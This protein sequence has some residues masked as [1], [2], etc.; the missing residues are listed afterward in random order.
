VNSSLAEHS[1]VTA[2][3]GDVGETASKDKQESLTV[4]MPDEVE[5]SKSKEKCQLESS[6]VPEK[7]LLEEEGPVT[8]E[9][10]SG[11]DVQEK[12]QSQDVEEVS[13]EVEEEHVLK[14]KPE[15][16]YTMVSVT[17]SHART[18]LAHMCP[19]WN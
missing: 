14:N 17:A 6:S 10:C 18:S 19:L 7:I 11:Q 8:T 3:S 13:S 9:T 4:D 2:N 16:M 5:L 12:G 15:L 1:T